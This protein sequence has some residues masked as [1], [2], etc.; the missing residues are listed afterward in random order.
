LNY[1]AAFILVVMRDAHGGIDSSCEP[2]AE[3]ADVF[4]IMVRLLEHPRYDMR[5]M[6]TAQL[7]GL[8]SMN[9][10]VSHLLDSHLPD[11][12]KALGDVGSSTLDLHEWWFT[13]GTYILPWD[14]L[15]PLWDHFMVEG[16]A[17]MLRTVMGLLQHLQPQLE[18]EEGD[19]YSAMAAL[20]AYAAHLNNARQEQMDAQSSAGDNGVCAMKPPPTIVADSN[21][22]FASITPGLVRDLWAKAKAAVAA[23]AASPPAA[24]NGD[25]TCSDAPCPVPL[26]HQVHKESSLEEASTNHDTRLVASGQDVDQSTLGESWM[27]VE[28]QDTAPTEAG[29]D[30]Q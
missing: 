20:K 19:L 22:H 21:N 13:L 28:S 24:A 10:V 5:C 17:P 4:T 7:P 14:M 27:V 15:E 12:A 2:D 1:I 9:C 29:H 6:F 18:A 3:E 25:T 8:H 16:W 26:T 30:G 11:V 23:A